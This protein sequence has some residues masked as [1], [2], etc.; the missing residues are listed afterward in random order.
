MIEK[1]E[2]AKPIIEKIEEAGYEAYF[3]G[4]SVRDYLLKKP[5]DDIDIA[6]SA[7]PEE[8]KNIFPKTIDVGI[9]HGTVVVLYQGESYEIT[10]FRTE[11]EY[12]DY[13]RPKEVKFVRSLIEDLQRRD[14]TMNAIAM[15]KEGELIDPFSGQADIR[16]KVIRTVGKPHERFNEDALRMMRAVRFVSQLS[17]EL[18]HETLNAIKQ[19]RALLKYISVERIYT[20]FTKLLKGPNRS[21]A[22]LL[23]VRTGL[24]QYLPKLAPYG[25][26]LKEIATLLKQNNL[27]VTEIWALLLIVIQDEPVEPF[28]REW[29]MSVK[30]IKRIK[31]IFHAYQR[32]INEEWSKELVYD[33]GL[34]VAVSTEKIWGTIQQ[35]DVKNEIYH[36]HQ[37]YEALP[38]KS[39]KELAVSGKDLMQ[40][41][42]KSSGPWIR[43]LIERIE[44]AVINEKVENEKNII[45]GWLDS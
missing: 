22:L 25:T 14:F 44:K 28:L 15:T 35:V 2:R 34:E 12:I 31:E 19:Y 7:F 11:T 33:T 24:Y 26:Q 27:T 4:G 3:V 20:E 17:F 23:L 42:N 6:T 1:F 32:R 36:L 8:I 41:F 43:E 13:R 39:R 29:K 40:W 38:I 16:K 10:T 21:K 9:T 45:K 30:L 37:L 18:H 5:I